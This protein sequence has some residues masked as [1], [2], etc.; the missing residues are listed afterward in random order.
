LVIP[1]MLNASYGSI[2]NASSVVGLYGNFGQT[3]YAACKAGLIALTK[4]WA[5]ELGP[6]GIRVNTVCPGFIATDMVKAIPGDVLK[7]LEERT[8]MK[9]L[10]EVEEVAKV[11]A[12][13]ASEESSYVNGSVIEVSGGISL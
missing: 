5:R 9:R 1:H 11:Y 4:T 6:K 13:L 8:W 3:N 7:T 10:G 2:V 12:F